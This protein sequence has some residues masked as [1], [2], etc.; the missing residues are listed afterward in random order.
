MK[1]TEIAK[2]KESLPK[3]GYATEILKSLRQKQN[4]KN[5]VTISQIHH[6]F[7]GRQ[8]NIEAQEKIVKAALIAAKKRNERLRRVMKMA[9]AA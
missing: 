9:A 4:A 1:R 6:F 2:L 8:V 3:R 7:N 5:K